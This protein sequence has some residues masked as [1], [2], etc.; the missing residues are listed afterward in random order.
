MTISIRPESISSLTAQSLIGELNAELSATYAEPGANHFGLTAADVAPGHGAFLVLWLDGVPMGCGA[1][2]LLEGDTFELKRM[3]VKAGGRGQGLGGKLVE[4]L[5]QEAI[6]TGAG[7]LV[8]ET[9]IRQHAAIALYRRH[10]F[11]PIP[12]YG[13]YH[14]SPGTSLCFGKELGPAAE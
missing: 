3:Y 4:A 12:L 13:E 9:G 6:R 2:R 8:L 1:V 5:E 7:R 14:V 11:Q 10:G